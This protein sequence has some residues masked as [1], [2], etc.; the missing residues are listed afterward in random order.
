MGNISGT[1]F[2]T[3]ICY[4]GIFPELSRECVRQGAEILVVITNDS[5]YGRTAAPSQHLQMAAFRAIETR[6]PLLRSANSGYTVVIDPLGQQGQKIGLFEEGM[7]IA[8]VAGNNYRSIYS[9]TGEWINIAL[10][11]VTLMLALGAAF[12]NQILKDPRDR[13]GN[14][15]CGRPSGTLQSSEKADHTPLGVSLT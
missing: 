12:E 11:G 14:K 10:I 9:Y 1:R 8:E 5:W 7:F 13:K 4:E 15:R 3:L 2:A 6:K